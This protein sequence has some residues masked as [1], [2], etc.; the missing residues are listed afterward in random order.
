FFVSFSGKKEKMKAHEVVWVLLVCCTFV[1]SQNVTED[2]GKWKRITKGYVIGSSESDIKIHVHLDLTMKSFDNKEDSHCNVLNPLAVMF[3]EAV[4]FA[5][6]RIISEN[7]LEG[8]TLGVIVIDTCK[9][10]KLNPYLLVHFDGTLI[11]GPY[12]S[13]LS[14]FTTKFISVFDYSMISYGASSDH[15]YEKREDFP[16]F[17]STVP[18]DNTSSQVYKELAQRMNWEYTSVIYT[19]NEDGNSM[20]VQTIERLFNIGYCTSQN[21]IKSGASEASYQITIEKVLQQHEIKVVFLFLAFKECNDFF[22]AAAPF[23]E[24]LASKQF[25]LGTACSA[26][27][28]IPPMVR[29][30]FKNMISIQITLPQPKEFQEYFANLQPGHNRRNEFFFNFYWEFTRNCTLH[31]RKGYRK[32]DISKSQSFNQFAPVRPIISAMYTAV[33]GI[34]TYC[35][36]KFPLLPFSICYGVMSK[37]MRTNMKSNLNLYIPHVRFKL[38]NRTYS[39]NSPLHEVVDSYDVLQY[40]QTNDSFQFKKIGYWDANKRDTSFA[41]TLNEGLNMT[42]SR[43]SLPCGEREIKQYLAL[44][45]CCWH[46]KKCPVHQIIQN[47]K[48]QPCELGYKANIEQTQCDQL[49]LVTMNHNNDLSVIVIFLTSFGCFIVMAVLFVYMRHFSSHIIKSSSRE[50]ALFSLFGL[51]LMLLVPILFTMEPNI[52]ICYGQ[53]I[54]VG[55]SL[56]CCY[57]PLVLKTNRVYRIF[58]SS[59]KFKLKR[60]MLVSMR[61][62]FLL[63]LAMAGIELLMGVF[64][65]LTDQPIIE[66]VYPADRDYVIKQCNISGTGAALNLIFPIALMVACT[67][68]AFKTRNLPETFSEIKS[69]GVTMYI[70]L[71]LATAAFSIIFILDGTIE[72]PFIQI[73]VVS[74]TFQ[75]IVFVNLI[76]QY[77]MKMKTLFSKPDNRADTKEQTNTEVS[78]VM[79]NRFI[80]SPSISPKTN[81]GLRHMSTVSETSFRN[82]PY[83]A[84][85]TTVQQGVKRLSIDYQL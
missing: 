58:A 44:A 78:I 74:F 21:D 60:L 26:G 10:T 4:L 52:L 1:A 5:A 37:E 77:A 7:L 61:S 6:D 29:P 42:D 12:S 9:G 13:E 39:R 62:Q 49:P 3:A 8:R 11:I 69:I 33:Y 53:K 14:D 19:S 85:L 75:A 18:A 55:L 31:G 82:D 83:Y 2:V 36:K 50:L 48:C 16:K 71:F 72:R 35:S 73:Y 23:K 22:Q 45:S 76:G 56:T 34:K 24:R 54:F 47:N 65:I 63:I 70:T 59:S 28:N 30:Y 25:V 38:F 27:V 43:C 40:V 17:F 67:F 15:F 32:C 57:S 41:L 79:T 80:S 51:F 68:W 81:N 46:C 64:W 84:N 20:M 66:T